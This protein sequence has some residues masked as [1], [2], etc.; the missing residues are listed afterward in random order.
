MAAYSSYSLYYNTPLDS[1][2]RLGIW[3]PRTIPVSSSDS[4]LTLS[5]AYN[6]RPDLLANDLYGDSRLWWIFSQRNP[7]ALAS[8]PLGK[9]VTGLKI[10]VPTVAN[11]KSML[12]I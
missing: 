4:V 6:L 8:D 2:G 9:F 5:P 1:Q 3:I 12:G 10:Y 11:I 7:N